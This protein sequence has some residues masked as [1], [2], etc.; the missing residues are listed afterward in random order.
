MAFFFS[1]HWFFYGSLSYV[2]LMYYYYCYN[3]NAQ[4]YK[5]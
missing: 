2:L 3:I 1:L 5:G 4:V